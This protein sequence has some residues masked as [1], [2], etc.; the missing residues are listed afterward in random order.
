MID[1]DWHAW[2]D[3]YDRPTSALSR[4]LA[5][6]Q[7]QLCAALDQAPPG[8]LRAVSLCAGQGRDLIGVLA[9]HPRGRDVRARLVEWDPRNAMAA[10]QAAKQAELSD[11]EVVVGDAAETDNYRHAVPADLVLACGVFG[12]LTEADVA[13]TIDYLPALCLPGGSVV[14]TRHRSVPDVVPDICGWLADHGFRQQ[15]LSDAAERH[16]VGRHL[17]AGTGEPVPAGRRMF[18]FVGHDRLRPPGQ[19]PWWA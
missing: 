15:W 11:V 13:A 12:N 19:P 18:T 1:R 16:G 2:H 4:R 7:A 17:F 8:R 5:D 10:Q 9:S 3:D 6:V 14:W